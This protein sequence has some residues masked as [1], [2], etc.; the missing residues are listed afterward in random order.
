MVLCLVRASSF[1]GLKKDSVVFLV[2]RVCTKDTQR[3]NYGHFCSSLL[4]HTTL[5]C[6]IP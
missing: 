1:V 3:P 5:Y 4:Y 6:T 2:L